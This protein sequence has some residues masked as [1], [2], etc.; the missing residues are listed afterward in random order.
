LYALDKIAP[1]A[2]RDVQRE[3]DRGY[4]DNTLRP[5][6]LP[7]PKDFRGMIPPTPAPVYGCLAIARGCTARVGYDAVS[8][9][10]VLLEKPAV[11]ALR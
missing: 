11:D 8:G 3:N 10:G 9:I 1:K 5:R 6:P 7:L 2:F 4:S